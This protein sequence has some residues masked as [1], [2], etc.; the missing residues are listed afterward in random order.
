MGISLYPTAPDID[1]IGMYSLKLY[2]PNEIFP[3]TLGNGSVPLF[4][5]IIA[6]VKF[7]I[8]TPFGNFI[9]AKTASY[10]FNFCVIFSFLEYCF[11]N[12]HCITRIGSFNSPSIKSF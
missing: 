10:S 8:N 3:V 11:F 1:I 4:V 5:N 6:S 9:P 7:N 12:I 2:L